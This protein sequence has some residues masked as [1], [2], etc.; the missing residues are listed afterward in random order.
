MCALRR[1]SLALFEVVVEPQNICN[2][3]VNIKKLDTNFEDEMG[4]VPTWV[5]LLVSRSVIYDVFASFVFAL[6]LFWNL[7]TPF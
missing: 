3:R 1:N 7:G 4:R 5:A 6:F 2:Q